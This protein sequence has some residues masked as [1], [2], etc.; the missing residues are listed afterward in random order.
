MRLLYEG[1]ICLSVL[2]LSIYWE[3]RN[4]NKVP[5]HIKSNPDELNKWRMT[6]FN[7]FAIMPPILEEL[8]F[9]GVLVLFFNGLNIYS[10]SAVLLISF[11]FA[12]AHNTSGEHRSVK[13]RWK[14][15]VAIVRRIYLQLIGGVIF[16]LLAVWSQSLL[17]VVGFHMLWNFCVWIRV[18]FILIED[19]DYEFSQLFILKNKLSALRSK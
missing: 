1:L 3:Y 18:Q 15:A 19:E 2:A 11:L 9:R 16:G 14:N 17:V 8:I 12:A 10:I 6:R 7:T 13:W 4:Q 5:L